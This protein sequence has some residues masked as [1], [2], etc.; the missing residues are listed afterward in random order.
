MRHT[1]KFL[2]SVAMTLGLA[3]FHLQAQATPPKPFTTHSFAE[4]RARHAGVPLVVHIWA[5]SCGPCLAEL[6]KWGVFAEHHPGV[7]LVLVRFDQASVEASEARLARS[8]LAA[9]ESW[10]V[11][12]EAD[13]YLRASVDRKWIGD[14][15]RTMLIAPDGEVTSI[16]GIADLSSVEHWVDGVGAGRPAR[17]H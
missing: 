1:L 13:E 10:G 5:M 7:A 11:A 2:L 14:V 8:G 15:P 17:G 9:V 3:C 16:R 12:G 4:I 6:P